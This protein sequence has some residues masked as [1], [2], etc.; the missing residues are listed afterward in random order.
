MTPAPAPQ[1][2]LP[3][4]PATTPITPNGSVIEDVI[5]RI[6]DQIITRTEYERSRQQLMEQARQ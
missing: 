2:Q 5:A 3:P 4:L 1:L 6:N